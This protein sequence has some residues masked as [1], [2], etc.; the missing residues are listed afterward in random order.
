[1]VIIDQFR[2]TDD[3]KYILLDAH[4]SEATDRTGKLLFGNV[5]LDT[6]VIKTASST[7]DAAPSFNDETDYIYKKTFDE[8]SAEKET[9]LMISVLELH[10]YPKNNF[11]EDLFF[12]FIKTKGAADPCVP[13]RCDEQITEAVTFDETVL[14]QRVMN[15]TKGLADDC[16]NPSKEFIDF[17]LKWN[18]FKASVETEH[19]ITA[20]KLFKE[21]FSGSHS[22]H[23]KKCGCHG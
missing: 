11:S 14:Y 9:H 17:I 22:F 7:V 6:I 5:F 16:N 13:C 20:I 3:G 15:Y 8:Y 12:L 23:V 21:M 4:V 19:W 18:A 2:I 1:M 10:T